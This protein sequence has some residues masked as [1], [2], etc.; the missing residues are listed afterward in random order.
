MGFNSSMSNLSASMN[1]FS[2]LNQERSP[3]L[4]KENKMEL[5]KLKTKDE[6]ESD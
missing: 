3:M 6:A 5:L 4:K 1:Q 2:P